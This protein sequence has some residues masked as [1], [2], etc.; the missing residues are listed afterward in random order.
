MLCLACT[1]RGAVPYG[2]TSPLW[3][4]LSTVNCSIRFAV[5]SGVAL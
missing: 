3:S 4:H 2:Q 5:C 1:K